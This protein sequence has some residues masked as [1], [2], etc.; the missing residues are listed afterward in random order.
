MAKKVFE[1]GRMS[2]FDG[3]VTLT[4]IPSY[5]YL[6]TSTYMQHFVEIE[7]TFCRRTDSRTDI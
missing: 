7:E 6:L 4:L 1:N 5:I 2:N 3:L